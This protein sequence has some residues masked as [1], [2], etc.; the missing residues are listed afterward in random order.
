MKLKK[1]LSGELWIDRYYIGTIDE[2]TTPNVIK[3]DVENQGNQEKN[4][5]YKKWKD[6]IFNHSY[7][8]NCDTK[9]F[10]CLQWGDTPKP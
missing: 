8:P 10:I 5:A 9:I 1:L 2:S 7:I 4:E 6:F 3:N